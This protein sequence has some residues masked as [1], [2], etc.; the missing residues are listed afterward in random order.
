MMTDD[1]ITRE[2][3]EDSEMVEIADAIR[4]GSYSGMTA[5]GTTWSVEINFDYEGG[6]VDE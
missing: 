5:S 3:F 6:G 4:G 1:K 2:D